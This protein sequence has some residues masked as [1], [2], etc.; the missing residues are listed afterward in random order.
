MQTITLT[1]IGV[2]R[3]SITQPV[4]DVWGGLISRIELDPK[5]FTPRSLAGLDAFSHIEVVYH[6]HSVSEKDICFEARHPRGRTDWPEVG[7]LA[8]RVKNRPNRLGI[9]VCKLLNV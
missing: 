5:L 3:N 8:Q 6:F 1:P 4:D 9:T 7:V 2:V